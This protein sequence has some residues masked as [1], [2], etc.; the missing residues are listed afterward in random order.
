MRLITF[1]LL[2]LLPLFAFSQEA[3]SK[4]KE[5]REE[6]ANLK[7]ETR[8]GMFNDTRNG[9]VGALVAGGSYYVS[10]PSPTYEV[11]VKL[12]YHNPNW[13]MATVRMINGETYETKGRYRVI[14]QS[15]EVLHEGEAYELKKQQLQG[16]T[17]GKDRFLMMPD[18]LFKRSGAVIYQLHYNSADYQLLEYHNAEWQEPQ[19]QNM[20][21]TREQHRTIKLSEEL[22]IRANGRFQRIKSQGDAIKIFGIGKKS[23]ASK[24]IKKNKLKLNQAADLVQF[25]EYLD[26][27]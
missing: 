27:Q 8:K 5:E 25:L 17:I 23:V 21:D 10:N 14:D 18:P 20:F 4:E 11:D 13:Q 16:I 12:A 15:F 24:Y 6:A 19:K 3:E 26:A 7:D 9:V 2:L 22:V 1:T